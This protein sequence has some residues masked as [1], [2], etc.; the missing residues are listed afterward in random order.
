MRAP[1]YGK[2]PGSRK[3]THNNGI[4][5]VRKLKSC[6][7]TKGLAGSE[8]T[9]NRGQHHVQ[10]AVSSSSMVFSSFFLPSTGI[11]TKVCP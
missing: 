9:T 5:I 8:D 4:K 7:K 3:A 6:E 2:I 1:F 10:T 11:A